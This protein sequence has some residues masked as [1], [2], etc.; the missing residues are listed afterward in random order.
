[1]EEIDWAIQLPSVHPGHYRWCPESSVVWKVISGNNV[2]SGQ[3]SQIN[4]DDAKLYQKMDRRM[5][6]YDL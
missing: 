5:P 6:V 1:M 3:E 2:V 4:Q